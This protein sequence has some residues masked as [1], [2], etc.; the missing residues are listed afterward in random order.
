MI[1]IKPLLKEMKER[2]NE[3]KIKLKFK[4]K[5]MLFNYVITIKSGEA[6][7]QLHTIIHK[8]IYWFFF[9]QKKKNQR[10]HHTTPHTTPSG[11]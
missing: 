9:F 5:L 8:N 6:N 1:T 10:Y 2:K 4:R 7:T 3:K 11:N